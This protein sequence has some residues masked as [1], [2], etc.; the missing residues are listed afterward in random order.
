MTA[1]P[2]KHQEKIIKIVEMFYPHAKIYLF[3]SYARNEARRTSDID[4]AIDA[5]IK[6]PLEEK[7]MIAN[8]IDALNL[9]QNVD[10]VDLNAI[11]DDFRTTIMKDAVAWKS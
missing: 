5:G 11:A 3:G 2:I 1:S 8:M 9:V 4:L 10:I 7:H 6:I